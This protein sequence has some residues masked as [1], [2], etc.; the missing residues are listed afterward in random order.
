MILPSGRISRYC[1]PSVH[2]VNFDDMP[3]SPARIIQK[4]APGPPRL[5]A[6]ATPAMLPSPTVAE[7]AVV[8][9]WKCDTSPGPSGSVYLPRVTW[10]ACPN[11]R[12]L[13]KPIRKVKKI[14]PTTS[15]RTSRGSRCSAS[16]N[17]TSQKKTAPITVFTAPID[18]STTPCH[19]RPSTRA[20]S[21][22]C[23]PRGGVPNG[24]STAAGAGA[25][26]NSPSECSA[27]EVI[28]VS[29][30]SRT[31]PALRSVMRRKIGENERSGGRCGAGRVAGAAR[32]VK[33]RSPR[34][35]APH[36]RPFSRR[37]RAPR[38]SRCGAPGPG[39]PRA[40]AARPFPSV[41][42]PPPDPRR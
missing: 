33:N 38:R 32:R 18:S 31:R 14:A 2:S 6:M 29:R 42:D 27:G 35:A 24:V 16:Q 40:G 20:S 4:V 39:D 25:W 26:A 7:S 34:T 5:T 41:A 3:S 11:A 15:Q 9:A 30:R 28:P 22:V 36:V 13:M 17:S 23:S 12:K 19:P 21:S 8:S 1:W 10:M 37:G